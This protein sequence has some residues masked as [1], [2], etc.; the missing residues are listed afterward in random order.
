MDPSLPDP[1]LSIN[2]NFNNDKD[3]SKINLG[4][5]AYKDHLLKPVVFQAVREAEQR[6]LEKKSDKEYN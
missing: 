5:G 1:I 6:I 2:V 3:P 4:V